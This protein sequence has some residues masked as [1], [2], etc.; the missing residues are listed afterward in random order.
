MCVCV[1]VTMIDVINLRRSRQGYGRS[2]ERRHE[3]G[4]REQGRGNDTVTV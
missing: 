3:K 1:C 4:G 2:W